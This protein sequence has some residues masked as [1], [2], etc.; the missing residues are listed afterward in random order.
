MLQIK[1]DLLSHREPTSE[2]PCWAPCELLQQYL[3][4]AFSTG[5]DEEDLGGPL[6]LRTD[7]EDT[8][9]TG[10][11]YTLWTTTSTSCLTEPA[12]PNPSMTSSRERQC[13]DE[14]PGPATL[15]RA[16]EAADAVS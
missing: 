10:T 11:E 14:K 3:V 6:A 1:S 9:D 13:P 7:M 5:G 12:W 4:L 16:A 8:S 2:R 15:H